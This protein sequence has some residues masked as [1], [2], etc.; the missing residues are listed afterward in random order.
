[1][2]AKPPQISEKT[3]SMDKDTVTIIGDRKEPSQEAIDNFI[4][5]YLSIIERIEKKP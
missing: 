4:K 3:R 2:E 5:V 1:M